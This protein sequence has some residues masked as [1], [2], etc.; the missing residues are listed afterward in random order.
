[1][2]ET[3]CLDVYFYFPVGDSVERMKHHVSLCHTHTKV[4]RKILWFWLPVQGFTWEKW[5]K[6]YLKCTYVLMGQSNADFPAWHILLHS[7]EHPGRHLEMSQIFPTRLLG[8]KD[9]CWSKQSLRVHLT[10]R[11]NVG[12]TDGQMEGKRVEV[13]YGGSLD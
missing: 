10:W 13:I 2:L 8:W 5:F 12:Q 1:M 11:R 3:R 9:L 6:I 4:H 7:T